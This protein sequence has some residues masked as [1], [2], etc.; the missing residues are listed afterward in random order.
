VNTTLNTTRGVRKISPENSMN[1]V[2]GIKPEKTPCSLF[3]ID[4]HFGKLG[5]RLFLTT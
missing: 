3:S 4:R 2:D 5:N 1:L